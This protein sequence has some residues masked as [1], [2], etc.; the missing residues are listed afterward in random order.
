[1]ILKDKEVREGDSFVFFAVLI[2]FFFVFFSFICIFVFIK[3]QSSIPL[4]HNYTIYISI[5][6]ISPILPS[7]SFHPTSLYTDIV[8]QHRERE[9]LHTIEIEASSKEVSNLKQERRTVEERQHNQHQSD[10]D[11]LQSELESQRPRPRVFQHFF[12]HRRFRI[13]HP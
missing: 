3:I 1:M 8:R 12:G 9:R 10:L 2:V 11:K 4:T 5:L 6:T 7:H 13:F